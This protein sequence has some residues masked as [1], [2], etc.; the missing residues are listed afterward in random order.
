MI[1]GGLRAGW[2][3]WISGHWSTILLEP[4]TDSPLGE[5]TCQNEVPCYA[6]EGAFDS[7]GLCIFFN[8]EGDGRPNFKSLFHNQSPVS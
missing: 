5:I 4:T 8:L 3:L 1:L 2:E 7:L 6:G